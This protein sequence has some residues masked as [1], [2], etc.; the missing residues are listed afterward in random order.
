[1]ASRHWGM[2]GRWIPLIS[3]INGA[4]SRMLVIRLWPGELHTKCRTIPAILDARDG[5][6][7][8]LYSKVESITIRQK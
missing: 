5:V 4:K 8:N 6:E 3:L 1:M 2:H 7:L